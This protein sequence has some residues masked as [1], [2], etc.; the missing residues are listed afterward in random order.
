MRPVSTAPGSSNLFGTRG[1]QATLGIFIGTFLY[2]LV[3]L[4]TIR[5]AEEQAPT[6]AARF[7]RPSFLHLA[8]F[9]ALALAI[10]SIGVLIY[11]VHH[12]TDGIHINN[13]IARIGR[14]LLDEIAKA[15]RDGDAGAWED[16]PWSLGSDFTGAVHP[17]R[18][19]PDLGRSSAVSVR[20]RAQR[21]PHRARDPGRF[22]SPEFRALLLV[23]PSGS[24][25]LETCGD[26]FSIGRKRSALQDFFDFRSTS[27]LNLPPVHCRLVSTI[28]S[29]LLPASTALGAALSDLAAM[30]RRNSTLRDEDGHVRVLVP[31][32]IFADYLHLAVGQLR[33]YAARDPNAATHL[34]RSLETVA[35]SVTDPAN[36]TIIERERERLRSQMKTSG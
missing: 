15:T 4:R 21:G 17:D 3:V 25:E 14:G 23:K 16:E 26:Y 13:V 20:D 7:A 9:G 27:W 5:S 22:R 36:R 19:C 18:V 24:A 6:L 33:P 34:L 10:T 2:C 35:E 11:F 12:V 30:P 31:R 29:Q 1:N 8:M 28:R 32:L